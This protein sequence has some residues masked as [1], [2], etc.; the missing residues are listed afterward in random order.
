M[1]GRATLPIGRRRRGRA[2]PFRESRSSA[3]RNVAGE[4]KGGSW[5]EQEE[6]Y[7][8]REM[9]RIGIGSTVT[10]ALMA[11]LLAGCPKRPEVVETVPK[12]A[13]QAGVGAPAPK[14]A[15][16]E[17]KSPTEVAA[18]SAETKPSETGAAPEARITEAEVKPESP[19]GAQVS[20]VKDIYF[21]FDKSAIRDD[22]KALLN[23][24]IEWL[25][26]N[27]AAKT[28]V[29]GHCDERGSS[30]YNLALGERRAR[31]A[32]D[33]LVAAGVAANRISTISFGKERPFV[34]GHDESAWKW[35]R[36]AHF[37]PSVK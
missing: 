14:V 17:E 28:I 24:N 16:P 29:E 9:P 10:V 36:R 23:E 19:A 32:R 18:E 7:Q 6:G 3:F 20:E 15:A 2:G 33:Y 11:I 22:S 35:N 5:R 21:D 30:E 12:P 4:Y 25:R 34:L 37:V 8:M 31:A 27:P 1:E 13:P 26:K